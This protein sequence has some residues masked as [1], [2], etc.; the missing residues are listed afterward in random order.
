MYICK[1]CDDSKI[2]KKSLD[3]HQPLCKLNPFRKNPSTWSTGNRK[4]LQPWNFGLIGDDRCKHSEPS[5]I[6]M[7]ERA[8][9]RSEDWH[10]ENG[11]RVSITVKEKVKDGTWH[12]SLAKN[13]HYEY[14]G[15]DLHGTWELK[16]AQYLDSNNIEWLRNKDSFIYT[17]DNVE[18]R[19]TPDFYLIESNE[20]IEIK[21]YKTEKDLSKWSQFPKDKKLSVLFEKDLK[22]LKII[23]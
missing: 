20:Y 23:S 7:S 18:R 8:K 22:N 15:N 12:T 6:L 13:M 17:Y 2:T 11:K 5:K 3:A 16:Y 14:K 1:F 10:K 21:G 19:Y 4:G 9:Q